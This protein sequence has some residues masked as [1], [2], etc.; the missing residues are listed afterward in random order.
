[1]PQILAA[2]SD[3]LAEAR[4]EISVMSKVDHDNILPLLASAVVPTTRYSK[5]TLGQVHS[6][7]WIVAVSCTEVTTFTWCQAEGR[8][9]PSL[10]SMCREGVPQ[11]TVYLL[12]PLYEV[13]PAR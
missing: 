9:G 6:P 13:S 11:H 3:Q 8:L 1:M 7:A 2:T 10:R 4:R 5:F 12:F